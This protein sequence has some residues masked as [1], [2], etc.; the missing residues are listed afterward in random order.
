[1]FKLAKNLFARSLVCLAVGLILL[2]LTLLYIYI[3]ERGEFLWKECS[4]GVVQVPY[5]R[6]LLVLFYLVLVKRLSRCQR[7]LNWLL[8]LCNG[9][10]AMHLT[11][12]VNF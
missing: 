3:F 7:C 12:E 8:G 6:S 4:I 11:I 5:V 1:M 10:S 9:L 2:D